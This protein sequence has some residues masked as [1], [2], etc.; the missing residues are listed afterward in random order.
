MSMVAETELFATHPI[1]RIVLL[2]VSLLTGACSDDEPAEKAVSCNCPPPESVSSSAMQYQAPG[3]VYK[4]STAGAATAPEQINR[5]PAQSYTAAPAQQG[6]GSQGQSTFQSEPA[7]GVQQTYKAPQQT[8]EAPGYGSSQPQFNTA[9]KILSFPEQAPST[10][11]QF[12]YDQRPWGPA[13]KPVQRRQP[14]AARDATRQQQN[15]YQWGS[16]TG[17]GGY[18][19]WGSG[20]YGATPPGAGYPGYVW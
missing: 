8:Y 14:S 16:P 20:P 11:Q 3:R 12:H 7:W 9:E 18:Y 4:R 15:P 1:F 17:G 2:C 6:W 19:G 5:I 10:A 13:D